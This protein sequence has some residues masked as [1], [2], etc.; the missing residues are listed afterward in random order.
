MDVNVKNTF[1]PKTSVITS[2][3]IITNNV[4]GSGVTGKVVRCCCKKTQQVY[5]LKVKYI[6]CYVCVI[7]F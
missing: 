5:A 4:L 3:Y 1:I 7:R 6:I 2:D